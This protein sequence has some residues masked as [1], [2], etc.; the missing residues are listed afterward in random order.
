MNPIKTI[1]HATDFSA[2]SQHALALA[3][4]LARDQKARLIVLHAVPVP[5]VVTGGPDK[6]AIRRAERSEQDLKDYRE[7]MRT[8]LRQLPLPGLPL[9][10]ER[11]L[12]EGD[13]P[14]V[15]LR[16]AEETSSDLILLGTHGWTA[17]A[18]R[19]LGSVAEE[20]SQKS[21]C[22][23]VTVKV[24]LAQ[25]QSAKQPEPEEAGVIL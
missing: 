1:L 15:I 10:V 6:L 11:L 12:K 17:E 13:V 2:H 19:L 4:A 24:P 14:T 9:A 3:C 25:P 16:T 7:E 5:A 18:R 8:K 20:V 21:R 23:V 22:P